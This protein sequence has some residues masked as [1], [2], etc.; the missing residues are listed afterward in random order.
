MASGTQWLVASMPAV[1]KSL[2]RVSCTEPLTVTPAFTSPLQ[3]SFHEGL[4]LAG[5]CPRGWW[6]RKESGPAS[7][8]HSL[9][10]WGDQ[11]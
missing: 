3:L 2:H 6:H 9:S 10:L 11:N 7:E 4:L 8:S 5:R 1:I